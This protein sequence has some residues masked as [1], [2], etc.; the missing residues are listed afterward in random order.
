MSGGEVLKSAGFPVR[1]AWR[2]DELQDYITWFDVQDYPADGYEPYVD[3]S[4][5]AR[6]EDA[7]G[8]TTTLARSNFRSLVRDYPDSF[9]RVSYSNVDALGAFV[10]DLTDELTGIL[11]G[12]AEQYPLYDESDLSELESDEITESFE[13]YVRYDIRDLIDPAGLETWDGDLDD[14]AQRELFWSAVD[15][16]DIYPE[17]DGLDVHWSIHYPAIGAEISKRLTG[18]S[19]CRKIG[20]PLSEPCLP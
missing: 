3:L 14:L 13:Q 4:S 2:P 12:L 5:V 9:T 1:Y 15:G 7:A 16:L 19:L 18:C 8:Q 11:V 10:A 17:H 20:H 6:G